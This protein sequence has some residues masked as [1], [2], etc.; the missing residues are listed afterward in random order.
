MDDPDK[1]VDYSQPDSGASESADV[2][3]SAVDAPLPEKIGRHQIE[4]I[5]GRGGFGL[6][7][8]AYDDQLQRSVAIKVPHARLFVQRANVDAYLAEA[9]MVA[10]LDHPHIVPVFDVGST[11]EF[12]C[13]IVSKYIDGQS[14]AAAVKVCRLSPQKAADL[15]ATVADTLHHAHK[16]G[17]VHRDIKPGNILLDNSGRPFVADFGLALREQDIGVGPR[18]AGTPA[19]MSPEQARGEG[20]RVDG[21]SDIFSLGVVLYELLT[22]RRPF[23][24]ASRDTLLDLVANAEA[25]PPRQ[26]DD[27][28]PRELERICLKALSKRAPD[29]YTTAKDLAD[30]LRLCLR[31]AFD[32]GQV[33]EADTSGSAIRSPATE[34][35]VTPTSAAPSDSRPLRIVPKGLRSFDA[36]DADFFLELLPGPCDR[37]GLPESLRFW[38]NLIE[39]SDAEATFSVGLICGP[40][41]CGKSSLVKAGL[42]P[43]L[44]DFVLTVYV[45]ATGSE[46]EARLLGGLRKHCPTL[47][48]NIGLKETLAALR[49][50]QGLPDGKK[51]LIV[52]DQFEQWLHV[53]TEENSELTQALRHCDGARTQ[54]LVLV[55]DDFWM[56]VIRFMRELEIRL[57][58]GQNS[59]AVDLFAVRHAQKVLAA[60]G[61]AFGALPSRP[62]PE[63]RQFLEQAVSGLAQQGKVIP[64]RLALFAEMMRN[65]PWTAAALKEVGGMEGIGVTFLN[66]TFSAA[67]APPEHRYHQ[68]AARGVLKAL[69]PQAGT[70]IKGQMRQRE[71]LLAASGYASRPADFEDLLRILDGEMRLI[72]PTDPAGNQPA[73]PGTPL[74]GNRFFQLAHDYLVPPLR[75][76]LTSKQ[77]ETRRG[78]A[79]LLLEERAATWA[80]K[81]DARQLPSLWQWLQ[82][83]WWTRKKAWTPPE[84]A[85]M[86]RSG[87]S[88][89][90]RVAAMSVLL[91]LLAFGVLRTR[92][93]IL[94]QRSAA[95]A[96]GMV[97]RLLDAESGQVPGIIAEMSEYRRWIDPLLRMENRLALDSSRKKLHTSLALLSVDPSQVEFLHSRLLSATPGE[98]LVIRDAL[99][100]FKEQL[101]ES[102]WKTAEAPDGDREGQRLRAAAALATYAP[103]DKRWAK[104]GE[105][106]AQDLVLESPAALSVWSGAL[107]PINSQ[108]QRPLL[109]VFNDRRA[110]HAAERMMATQLLADSN[111]PFQLGNLLLKADE[112]QFA[113]L[114][115]RFK[116]HLDLF[117]WSRTTVE[118]NVGVMNTLGLKQ[119]TLSLQRVPKDPLLFE[120]KSVVDL[121]AW[122]PAERANAAVILLKTG[123]PDKAWE[124]LKSNI[125]PGARSRLIHRLATFR[126]DPSLLVTRLE[127]E[128]DPS[129]QA[130]LLLALGEYREQ[131]IPTTAR[132]RLLPKLREL[133]RATDPGLHAAAEWLL[134]IWSQEPWLKATNAE[135]A[136]TK[137]QREQALAE[138]AQNS[139]DDKAFRRWYVNGQGQTMIVLPGPV[140]FSMGAAQIIEQDRKKYEDWTWHIRRI[141]RTFALAAKPVTVEQ[142]REFD[143]E[144]LLPAMF[145]RL[146]N[147]PVASVSW[148][149]AA[150]YCNWLSAQEGIAEDQWCYVL[151]G[152]ENLKVLEMR[153][154]YLSLRG[155]RLP[156]EAEFEYAAQAGTLTRW[157]FG[158]SEE[159]LPKYAWY[160]KSSDEMPWPVAGLKPNDFGFFDMHSNVS[161][162]CQGP[163]TQYPVGFADDK[164]DTTTIED[165]SL[166]AMR[167]G[168]YSGPSESTTSAARNGI[169]PIHSHAASGFRPART[170][171]VF[172][173][174]PMP[175]AAEMKSP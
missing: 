30:D 106:V 67:A 2:P 98:V 175:A 79:E 116:Q 10:S 22:G 114:F 124:V 33:A 104:I 147:L 174:T 86:T 136:T 128:R 29:R 43:R 157:S 18:F 102:L 120:M 173:A 152:P 160:S 77:R 110:E 92:G 69:L 85:V 137:A 134:R 121:S 64:V 126:V 6:V 165:T 20:H 48:G 34:M 132:D 61:R 122:P 155:Y 25:R 162:W 100:P 76:W 123:H 37:D 109:K 169:S 26:T 56:A 4:R 141:G 158:S 19:Y 151:K 24:S 135:L 60:Y 42:M 84:R 41:G 51:V 36:H 50:G 70:D 125:D 14:L 140:S 40:S 91:A 112:Q 164:E 87:R 156:T 83:R 95:E 31:E 143:K 12:P 133:Y 63:E 13:F 130:A 82:I 111:G 38:K 138:P 45:E 150:R 46:T 107:S 115:P 3:E 58:E 139:D 99:A 97:K 23:H 68:R 127:Q 96:T 65:R 57:Q 55:R 44:G 53:Q 163:Y 72:T 144:F 171:A 78:R 118:K 154:D 66:E 16:H 62:S 101:L 71:E 168:W 35:P 88:H 129:I 9:R 81:P 170:I 108:L 113:L 142:Y 90:F 1:T 167:G 28:I 145:T 80:A 59:S 105:P 49:R 52:L 89:G 17:L 94:E 161:Q 75:E 11:P 148:H 8:L 15:V 131:A 5:L 117:D 119:T 47:P 73:D 21:R 93:Q 7:Y 39:E 74:A 146:P 153:P 103:A 172:P 27:G 54:C 159:M 166:R 149:M 32:N